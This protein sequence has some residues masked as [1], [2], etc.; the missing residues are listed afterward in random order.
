M[1][2]MAAEQMEPAG[3]V[4][5]CALVCL[6]TRAMSMSMGLGF[7][8]NDVSVPLSILTAEQSVQNGKVRA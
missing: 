7:K 6:R 5:C 1:Y 3:K 2:G 8:K 4:R